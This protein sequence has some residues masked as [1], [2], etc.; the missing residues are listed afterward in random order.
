MSPLRLSLLVSVLS[1]ALAVASGLPVAW[2][3]ARRRFPGRGLLEAAVV[4]PIVLPPTVLGYYLLVLISRRGPVGA[5]FDRA[6]VELAFTWKAAVLAS[7]IG[8]YGMFV[9]AAQGGLELVDV[10][11]EQAARTLGRTEW[12]VFRRVTLPL[13]WRAVLA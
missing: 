9:K 5:L 12:G 13:A 11:I 6:G 1:T 3:L 2:L 4:L 8:S 7:W 10:R